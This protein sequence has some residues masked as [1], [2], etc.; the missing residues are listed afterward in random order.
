MLEIWIYDYSSNTSCK[1]NIGRNSSLVYPEAIQ[2]V[3][4]DNRKQYH[5][6]K[7]TVGI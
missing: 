7:I 5:K 3:D 1:E 2:D 6:N 4:M